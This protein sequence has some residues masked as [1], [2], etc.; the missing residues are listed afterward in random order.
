MSSVIYISTILE[1]CLL[2]YERGKER[3]HFQEHIIVIGIEQ[4]GR[5]LNVLSS[6]MA[7]PFYRSEAVLSLVRV[8]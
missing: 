8:R 2:Y 5:G 6:H 7:L 1:N 3:D 4:C